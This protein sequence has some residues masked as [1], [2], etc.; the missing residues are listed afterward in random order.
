[1]PA[2]LLESDQVKKVVA[3]LYTGSKACWE[4]I[5]FEGHVYEEMPEIEVLNQLLNTVD[6]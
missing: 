2:G 1:V 5:A 4:N 6:K 3:H